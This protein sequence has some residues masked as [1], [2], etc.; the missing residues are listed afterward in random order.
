MAKKEYGGVD[1]IKGE[2]IMVLLRWIK[3]S[4]LSFII[5]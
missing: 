3:K 2:N 1:L 4:W 5:S